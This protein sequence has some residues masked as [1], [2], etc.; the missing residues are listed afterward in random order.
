MPNSVVLISNKML[1]N[2][3]LPQRFF[4]EVFFECL[5]YLWRYNSQSTNFIK[6]FHLRSLAVHEFLKIKGFTHERRR[7]SKEISFY[8][9]NQ[10]QILWSTFERKWN[11]R[12]W[13]IFYT[14]KK[15]LLDV[16]IELNSRSSG[17]Y[18]EP[19]NTVCS[20]IKGFW[21]NKYRFQCWATTK[22]NFTLE[23]LKQSHRESLWDPRE[24]FQI[25]ETELWDDASLRLMFCEK[26]SLHVF[27]WVAQFSFSSCFPALVSGCESERSTS[28]F[29]WSDGT[30]SFL[31][32]SNKLPNSLGVT[33]KSLLEFLM[34]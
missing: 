19:S 29:F 20:A 26:F 1:L 11:M 33:L 5:H 10:Q 7:M 12:K 30:Q 3:F 15:G 9:N 4:E 8:G 32:V 13:E 23:L 25:N 6:F 17:R 14:T 22:I 28:T 24:S 16:D 18:N 2:V 27:V 34:K 21:I 31:Q